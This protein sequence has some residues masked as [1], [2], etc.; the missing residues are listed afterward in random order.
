[1]S[2]PNLR[3]AGCRSTG[4]NRPRLDHPLARQMLGE[5]LTRRAALRVKPSTLV[6]LAMGCSA[7]ISS[8]VAEL[9]S[10]WKASSI[11]RS[12]ARRV[13]SAGQLAIEFAR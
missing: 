12:A 11:G 1:M 6:V 3:S 13:P 9:S 5:G 8:S 10:S 4:F 7:A 2:S